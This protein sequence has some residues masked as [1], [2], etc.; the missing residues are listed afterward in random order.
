LIP[1][2]PVF[3]LGGGTVRGWWQHEKHLSISSG[4]EFHLEN[5]HY[6]LIEALE[7]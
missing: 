2:N 6:D 4:P 3:E 5:T 7:V 1:H